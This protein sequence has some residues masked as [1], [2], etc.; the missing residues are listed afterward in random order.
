[1]Q[2]VARADFRQTTA[3]TRTL[4][5]STRPAPRP[6]NPLVSIMLAG[7]TQQGTQGIG[8]QSFPYASR[9][10]AYCCGNSAPERIDILPIWLMISGKFSEGKHGRDRERPARQ[11][12]T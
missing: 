4:D 5:Y 8:R 12:R 11:W 7:G 1:M 2:T 9:A 6:D 10:C 3:D